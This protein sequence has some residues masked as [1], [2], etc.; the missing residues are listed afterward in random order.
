MSRGVLQALPEQEKRFFLQ[1]TS[2]RLLCFYNLGAK[3]RRYFEL[4]EYFCV[5]FDY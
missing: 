4:A 5:F 1:N 2:F 3:V